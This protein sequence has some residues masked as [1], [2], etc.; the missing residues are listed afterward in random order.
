VD[1]SLRIA[2]VQ[3]MTL[4][5]YGHRD[6]DL[7]AI[8]HYSVS[9]LAAAQVRLGDRPTIHLLTSGRSRRTEV[10][11]YEVVWHRCLQRQDAGIERR[12]ARQASVRRLRAVRQSTCDLV[13]FHGV[14]QL[15]VMYGMLAWRARR[16]G[17]PFVGQDRGNR[18]VGR[19][20]TCA[21]RIGVRRSDLLL[22]A[23]ADSK[24]VLRELGAPRGA[25]E[26][27]PN[28]YDA[29]RFSAGD[30]QVP[31]AGVPFRVLSVSRLNDDKDPLTM[32]RGVVELAA[33][34]VPV[35]LTVVSRGPLRDAV[36]DVLRQG[37]VAADFIDHVP[38]DELGALYR[39]H[40]A[41]VLTS[42]R[43]G[44]NQT[45]L[46]AMAS[47]VPIVA[48]DI[49]GTAD[50]T[51]GVAQLVPIRAPVAVADALER[52]AGDPDEWRRRRDMGLERAERFTWDSVAEQLR[53]LYTRVL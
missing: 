5:L 1:R 9:N 6:E 2:H 13:H 43:E 14:R 25:I 27:L 30:A 11:G 44:F 24:R 7:G 23:S 26:L 16:E 36:A 39:E 8:V 10:Q 34:G 45:V 3:P 29:G 51:A 46:E 33:R 28:G 35:Q 18:E 53:R 32:A 40:H 12:F 42:L 4:D 49:P 15:H 21:Q 20:E 47:G 38:Q 17:V 31:A 48:T 37:G 50:A 22:A 52:L 41:Y 19:I